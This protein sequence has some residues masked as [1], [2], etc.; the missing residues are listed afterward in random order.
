MK[1]PSC[2]H[3]PLRALLA[4]VAYQATPRRHQSWDGL[5]MAT[6]MQAALNGS[7]WSVQRLS[8]GHGLVGTVFTWANIHG[9]RAR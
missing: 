8:K 5:L 4:E 1:L 7:G 9:R 3:R 2:K 6:W